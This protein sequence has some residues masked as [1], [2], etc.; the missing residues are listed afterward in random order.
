M[1]AARFYEVGQLLVVEEVPDPQ[2]PKGEVLLK[3]RA[4]GAD[5]ICRADHEDPVAFI[6]KAPGYGGVDLAIECIGRQ[7]TIA[8]AV[9]SLRRGG[10]AVVLGLGPEKNF[11]HAVH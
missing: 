2:P 9:A 6:K 7:D 10:R 8:M 4:C 5:M 11:H 1:M 3:T